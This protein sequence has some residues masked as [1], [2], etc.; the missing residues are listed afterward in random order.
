MSETL[1]YQTP[2]IQDNNKP[3][4]S[5]RGSRNFS[6]SSERYMADQINRSLNG[7]IHTRQHHHNGT[8]LNGNHRPIDMETCE[9][10]TT[11]EPPH[12]CILPQDEDIENLGL[13]TARLTQTMSCPKILLASLMMHPKKKT[14][15]PANGKSVGF[16]GERACESDTP[17]E[18]EKPKSGFKRSPTPGPRHVRK[19]TS[20]ESIKTVTESGVQESTIGRY[21]YTEKSAEAEVTEEYCVV[22]HNN[23]SSS[24][25]PV[26]KPRRTASAG[27]TNKASHP[28]IRSS[29][30][31]DVLQV[32]NNGVEITETV[33]HIY[34]RQGGYD[35][36]AKNE[37]MNEDMQGNDSSK[38]SIPAST[39]SR[40]HSGSVR[41]SSTVDLMHKL[42]EVLSS[43]P[44]S[45]KQAT[46]SHNESR[47]KTNPK[48]IP[49]KADVLEKHNP[50]QGVQNK[51]AINPT[52]NKKGFPSSS[53]S[54]AKQKDS[55][56][57]TTN[58]SSGENLRD[59]NVGKKSGSSSDSG[60]KGQKGKETELLQT[61]KK[62]R[63][64]DKT[65]SK[66]QA[67]SPNID[68]V[69][70]PSTKS[71]VKIR[72]RAPRENGFNINIPEKEPRPP[73]KKNLLDTVQPKQL[74]VLGKKGTNKQ[75]FSSEKKMTLPKQTG[76]LSVSMPVLNPSPSEVHQYVEKWLQTQMSPDSVPYMEEAAVEEPE[77]PTKVV[78]QIGGDSDSETVND[79]QTN[80][81]GH[82][83]LHED[84]LLTSRSCLP[85]PISQEGPITDNTQTAKELCV[86]KPSIRIDPAEQEKTIRMHRSSEA[87]GPA[88]NEPS[89]STSNL[90][91]TQASL[92]PV[93]QQLCSS[94]QCIRR[95]SEPENPGNIA[96]SKK[97]PDFST[98]VAS[99][100]ESPSKAFLSFLSVMTLRETLKGAVAGESHG[101]RSTSEAMLVMESLQK[102]STIEDDVLQRSSLTDLQNRTSSE[103]KDSWRD[104]QVLRQ[105]LISE[106]P[107]PKFSEQEFA[108][109]VVSEAGEIFA[110]Q[111]FGI[112]D[113]M[114]ELN[115]PQDLR[116]EISS[117]FEQIKSFYPEVEQSTFL[118]NEV[119][120]SET[121]EELEQFHKEHANE[122]KQS[123]EPDSFGI[124]EEKE[125]SHVLGEELNGFIKA[126]SLCQEQN[127]L[128]SDSKQEVDEGQKM[129]EAGETNTGEHEE[130]SKQLENHSELGLVNDECGLEISGKTK[131][132]EV[133]QNSMVDEYEERL[134]G[135]GG[136][137]RR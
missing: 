96:K 98:Q 108:L 75:K 83:L 53:N 55:F 122:T 42:K 24:S 7:S 86:S 27:A 11:H 91:T 92:K 101:S 46:S 66:K 26:P 72:K 137:N 97:L 116:E 38:T 85:V 35:N 8:D 125:N 89:S 135:A 41:P 5:G 10:D 45:P 76:E 50:A 40:P 32:E 60:K 30:V 99:V 33:M 36:L 3:H 2:S 132:Q 78:F 126:Q 77:P 120:H 124:A 57:K 69:N 65:S 63:R 100:F 94:I 19:N 82:N 59:H 104:F 4:S 110:D 29:A 61:A 90:L 71:E 56:S 52:G 28:S 62:G 48:W 21:S 43:E 136:G 15:K 1:Q 127:D 17:T 58:G 31:A 18:S 115:M 37:S 74:S 16:S 14:I 93:L 79:C 109:D 134:T 54:E 129:K 73:M 130:Q 102:I 119:N 23:T 80:T 112:K 118:V 64:A 114:E 25:R 9:N 49:A 107:S 67:I 70:E 106:P 128:L 117:T 111:S 105:R 123:Q 6:L 131:E 39:E 81:S 103:L 133:E 121:E 13:A 20:V 12:A 51:K 88:E 22:R 87:I 47:S 84:A 68:Q 95:A 113:L 34:E 44:I